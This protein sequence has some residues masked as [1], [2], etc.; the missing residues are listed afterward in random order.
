MSS[1]KLIR[2][3]FVEYL[4]Q[5]LQNTHFSSTHGALAKIDNMLNRRRSF[6]TFQNLLLQNSFSDPQYVQ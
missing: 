5:H 1:I 6:N 2:F 4:P 3:I